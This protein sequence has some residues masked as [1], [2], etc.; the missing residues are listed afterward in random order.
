LEQQ[1]RAATIQYRSIGYK[2]QFALQQQ[3]KLKKYYL[4]NKLL[5]DIL[6]S[7]AECYIDRTTRQYIIDTFCRPLAL[8]PPPPL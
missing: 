2:W 7:E 5:S 1:L 8:I 3:E 4:A 6:E